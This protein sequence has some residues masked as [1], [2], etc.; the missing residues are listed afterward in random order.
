MEECRKRAGMTGHETADEAS[1][2][3]LRTP[4]DVA[5]DCY[6]DGEEDGD[7][8]AWLTVN[9]ETA[10]E[11]MQKLLQE[12]TG[13]PVA[14][15]MRFVDNSYWSPVIFQS[16][17]SYITINVGNEETCGSSFSDWE[18]S[19]MASVDTCGW[20]AFPG[21]AAAGVEDGGGEEEVKVMGEGSLGVNGC[22]GV[23]VEWD[24][25]MLARFLGDDEDGTVAVGAE[26]RSLNTEN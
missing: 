1:G 23:E 13:T 8:L 9:E 14:P 5:G 21:A 26:E 24:D 12:E 11:L 22:D 7:M 20:G 4:P 16:S 6:N 2:K 17:S 15:R 3:R 19:V 10:G 25:E 18:A